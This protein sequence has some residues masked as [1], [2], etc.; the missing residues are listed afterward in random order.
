M[1][2]TIVSH[3]RKHFRGLSRGYGRQLNA[4]ALPGRPSLE[5]GRPNNS[6]EPIRP[7]ATNRIYDGFQE[8]AGRL[9]SR[10]LAISLQSNRLRRS[11]WQ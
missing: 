3:R 6:M 4:T 2:G 11:S 10:P 7:T 9:I 1:A 5:D 8:L